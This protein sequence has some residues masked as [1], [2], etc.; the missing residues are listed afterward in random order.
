MN[1]RKW[2][3]A[4]LS[5][6]EYREHPTRKYGILKDRYYR[7]RFQVDGKRKT[8]ALGWSSE[9]WTE[10]NAFTELQRLRSNMRKGKGPT[11]LKEERSLKEA[12]QEHERVKAEED[13]RLSVSFKKFFDEEYFPQAT[14]EKGKETIRREEHLYRLWIKPVIGKKPLR[15]IHSLDIERIKKKM[16]DKGK[17]PRTIEYCLAVTRQV[18]NYAIRHDII[19]EN[20]VNKVKKPKY[21]NR[22]TRYLTH[23]EAESLLIALKEKSV[24][25]HDQALISLHTGMRA[26]E[27]FSL[28]WN[29]IHFDTGHILIRGETAKSGKDRV[30]YM[31]S[32]VRS[33]LEERVNNKI[34]DY[35]FYDRR[36]KGRIDRVSATFTRTIEELK[37]N[38]EALN[39]RDRVTFHTLRHTFASWL[40]IAGENLYNI[41]ELLGHSTIALTERYSHLSPDALQSSVVRFEQALGQEAKA[42]AAKDSF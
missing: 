41:K 1:T 21:E 9:K 7:I 16:K 31:T 4:K 34:N 17:A 23:K 14:S 32:L 6:V 11:S 12:E 29:D 42:E 19:L 5:G 13:E 2:T 30:V 37:L 40:A 15:D 35:V 18:F 39:K 8:V 28:K 3:P 27:V 20:P 36:H 26:G 24:D 10:K 38:K 33:M 22:R 25:M